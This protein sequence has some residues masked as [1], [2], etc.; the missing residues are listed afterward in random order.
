MKNLEAA[1][2]MALEAH[3]G[4][5]DR[6]G[7]PY[8]FHCTS[9][10]NIAKEQFSK[11]C[12]SKEEIECMLIAALLH[13]VIEDGKFTDGDIMFRF[14][15]TVSMA[16][17]TLTKKHDV[18]YETYI[19]KIKLNKIAML[20]KMADLIHNMDSTRLKNIT[21]KD[22]ERMKKY[23]KAYLELRLKIEEQSTIN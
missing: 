2:I 7:V 18:K 11:Y 21:D 15:K 5:K 4:Q 12:D 9:V 3:K 22:L 19:E 17:N 20:V 13:D 8:I 16:V 10:M 23:E 6:G 14:G 1:L